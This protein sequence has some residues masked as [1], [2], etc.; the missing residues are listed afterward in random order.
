MFSRIDE[1]IPPL[2]GDIDAIPFRDNGRALLLLRD[3]AGYSEQLLTFP[4]EAGMLFSLFDGTRSVAQLCAEF[5]I[6]RGRLQA[7]MKMEL[8]KNPTLMEISESQRVA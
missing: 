8:P 7:I 3:P 5:F 6:G 4:A 2:R 1:P